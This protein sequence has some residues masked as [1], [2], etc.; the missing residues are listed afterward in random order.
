MR[1]L[2]FV[3][4]L[5]AGLFAN[6]AGV[7]E[8]AGREAGGTIIDMQP[9]RQTHSIGIK[10]AAGQQ[11]SATLINLNPGVNAWY[12]LRLSRPGASEQEIYHL[13]N[14][15]ATSRRLSLDESNPYG[16]VIASGKERSVCDLWGPDSRESL[17][18]ARKSGSAF[19]PLCEGRIYLRNPVKGHRTALESVTEVLR[20]QVPGGERVISSVRDTLFA[21]LYQRRAGERIDS[22]T[23]SGAPRSGSVDGPLPASMDAVQAAKTV[24]PVELGIDVEGVGADG[25]IPGNWYA[26]KGNPGIYAGVIVP[27]WI[28]PEIMR[29]HR[30][31]VNGL[32][33]VELGQLVYLVAFD[34]Q[35][36]DLRYSL[37]TDQP[38]LGW[39]PRA[40]PQTRDK[41]LPG[42]DGIGTG[43]PLVR[44][45]RV[46]PAEAGRTVAAFTG[47]FKRHHGAF[48]Y[49][50][51]SLKN[52]G[53][54]YGFMESGVIF[55]TLQPGLATLYSL[56]D[57]RVDMRTW[58]GEDNKIL[59][60]VV[61]ARQNGVPLITGFDPRS[62][63]SQP[64]PLVA[65]WGM[66]NWS[67]SEDALLQTMRA[68]A[69][70]QE[71]NGRRFLIYA[72]F[73]SATPSAMTRV[74]QAYRCC[75]AMLLDM[76]ALVHTYL[77]VYRR[78]EGQLCLQHLI[79]GM[80]EA[81]VYV[82]G[83]YIPRFLGFSDDRDFFYLI[84]K[85]KP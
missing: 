27:G 72:F 81:D 21:Y 7:S 51:L 56:T 25:M 66:G 57:G 46:S 83:R 53:S 71:L 9:F 77:A 47:G 44:T 18:S 68:G 73:W 63:M 26:A 24:K 1:G 80:G 43:A 20:D 31:V 2:L 32:D 12:L 13:E 79:R 59:P 84:R 22:K 35:R 11:G 76:N 54:H 49:G 85:E 82:K 37:G 8:S 29:S 19:A 48:K 6:P 45:G 40:V 33:S 4:L 70:L 64:G 55:S 30:D 67:G 78:R 60:K 28:A 42:P 3:L 10:G 16:L 41:T 34:L 5:L 61:D 15:D 58:T 65:R 62:R 38:G 23:L 17:R 69:A 39:S 75:Y 36:F 74:F 14:G 50:D 52:H